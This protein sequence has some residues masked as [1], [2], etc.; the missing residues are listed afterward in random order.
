[1]RKSLTNAKLGMTISYVNQR[2]KFF[3]AIE[4]VIWMACISLFIDIFNQTLVTM[5]EL[6]RDV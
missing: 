4:A 1:M 3:N 5:G 2:S 6:K